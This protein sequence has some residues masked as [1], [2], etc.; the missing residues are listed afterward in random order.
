MIFLKWLKILQVHHFYMM[1]NSM[2]LKVLLTL[3][4]AKSPVLQSVAFRD[5][6]QLLWTKRI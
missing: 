1:N 4:V 6:S 5:V 3:I 2:V